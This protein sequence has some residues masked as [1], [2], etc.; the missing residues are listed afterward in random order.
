MR[1]IL[2]MH[3]PSATGNMVHQITVDHPSRNL[4]D[5]CVHMNEQQFILCRLLYREKAYSHMEGGDLIWVDKGLMVINTNHIGKVTEFKE[6]EEDD[7][8][9]RSFEQRSGNFEG[10]RPPLRA[11]GRLL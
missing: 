3:M 2:T 5:L 11:R 8:S 7:E 9:L 6:K 1:Y 4:N 10:K